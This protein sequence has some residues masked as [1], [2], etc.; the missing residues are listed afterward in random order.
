MLKPKRHVF[1]NPWKVLF[2]PMDSPKLKPAAHT[3]PPLGL[4]GLIS[5]RVSPRWADTAEPAP[6][7]KR[8]SRSSDTGGNH[9]TEDPPSAG[10]GGGGAEEERAPSQQLLSPGVGF[11]RPCLEQP[12]GAAGAGP[13]GRSFLRK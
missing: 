12:Q 1:G 5:L 2:P 6:F 3:D 4:C 8:L 10:G 9:S 7:R 13:S 11:L